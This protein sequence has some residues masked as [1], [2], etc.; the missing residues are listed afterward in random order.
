VAIDRVGAADQLDQPGCENRRA[1]RLIPGE[2]DDRELV[3][4]EPGDPVG[5][6]Q[7]VSKPVG[8]ALEKRVPDRM[9]E[10]VVDRFEAV[11]VEEENRERFSGP[12]RSGERVI[13]LLAEQHA[14]R[15]AGQGVVVCEVPDALLGALPVRHLQL[16]T[17]VEIE[18]LRDP[19]LEL[20]IRLGKRLVRGQSR[21]LGP[22]QAELRPGPR[23][24]D[25]EV[26][27]LGDV[28]VGAEL[29][30]LDDVLALRHRRDHDDRKRG[31]RPCLANDLEHLQAI[32]I[33]HDHIEQHEIEI[34]LRDQLERPTAPVRLGDIETVPQEPPAQDGT[35]VRD[36]VDDE[37]PLWGFGLGRWR[38]PRRLGVGGRVFAGRRPVC[39][40][41]HR[42]HLLWGASRVVAVRARLMVRAGRDSG[43]CRLG[44]GPS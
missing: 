5:V 31:L 18:Q 36:V 39:G 34:P 32:E 42:A 20:G 40:A 37:Q 41:G 14:V 10:R 6:A 30:R 1:S 4:A 9:A 19:V 21:L 13:E 2:L 24:S 33:R 11:Q 8:D 43:A 44:E 7:A 29:E 23:E 38:R 28:V 26:D 27:R 35:V 25:R 15:Q 3:T 22:L 17:P 12:L 16:E